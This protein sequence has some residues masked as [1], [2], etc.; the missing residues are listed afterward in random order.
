MSESKLMAAV[1]TLLTHLHEPNSEECRTALAVLRN[2]YAD[3]VH[4]RVLQPHDGQARTAP[5]KMQCAMLHL[6]DAE[7]MDLKKFIEAKLEPY[8]IDQKRKS[9]EQMRVYQTQS[10]TLATAFDKITWESLMKANLSERVKRLNLP[11]GTII[12]NNGR[13]G[14]VVVHSSTLASALKPSKPKLPVK[15]WWKP[16]I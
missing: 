1:G 8:Y 6:S 14:K 12:E 4:D 10:Q 7:L 11:P 16:F 2:E 13:T 5:I 15:P 3:A 9:E